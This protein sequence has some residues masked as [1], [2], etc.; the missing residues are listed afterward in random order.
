MQLFYP[1]LHKLRSLVNENSFYRYTFSRSF[2][3]FIDRTLPIIHRRFGVKRADALDKYSYQCVLVCWKLAVQDPSY[4]LDTKLDQYADF[5]Q[6][7]YEAYTTSGQ[8]ISFLVW[9]VLRLYKDG[10]LVCKGIVHC[11]GNKDS[12]I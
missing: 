10:P 8:K 4:F 5:D 7:L 1:E 3:Q 6:Q 2:Q 11:H 12:V 9:P